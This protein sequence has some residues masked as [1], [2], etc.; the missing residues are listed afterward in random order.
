MTGR[1][2]NANRAA[3]A[4]RPPLP[5]LLNLGRQETEQNAGTARSAGVHTGIARERE[6]G[7][8]EAALCQR[9]CRTTF[10]W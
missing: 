4:A 2:R 6:T 5:G 9:E 10:S 1:Y 7:A 3:T 8:D